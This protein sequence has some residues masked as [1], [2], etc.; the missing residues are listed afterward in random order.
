MKNQIM[1]IFQEIEKLDF[2]NS[3]FDLSIRISYQLIS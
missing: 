3:L 1:L 2:N